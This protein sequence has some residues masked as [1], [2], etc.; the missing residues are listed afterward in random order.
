LTPK[1]FSRF[2]VGSVF[3]FIF[4]LSLDFTQQMIVD[5]SAAETRASWNDDRLSLLNLGTKTEKVIPNLDVRFNF[6]AIFRD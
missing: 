4:D 6:A 3:L 1:P 2:P 5:L